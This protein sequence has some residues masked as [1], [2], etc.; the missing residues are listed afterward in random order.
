MTIALTLQQYLDDYD[1]PYDVLAHQRTLT[2]RQTARA[3]GIPAACLAK[4]VVLR[5]GRG[6]LMAVLPA[7]CRLDPAQLR[8]LLD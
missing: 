6:Y 1:V 5:D 8:R 2:A 4:A 3:S 7:S